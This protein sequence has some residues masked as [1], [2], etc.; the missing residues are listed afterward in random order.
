MHSSLILI[1]FHSAANVLISFRIFWWEKCTRIMFKVVKK[2]SLIKFWGILF[3]GQREVSFNSSLSLVPISKLLDWFGT[4]F[5]IR[6]MCLCVC[7]SVCMCSKS[8]QS[9]LTLCEPMGHSLPVSSVYG[10]LQ[11]RILEWVVMPLSKGSSQPGD[12]TPVSY[13][14]CI[15][16][17]VLYL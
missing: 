3:E 12:W 5:L 15:G 14:S 4:A 9:C 8:F 2:I 7:L 10:I 1:L 11:A 6:K 13:I 16:R 17:R